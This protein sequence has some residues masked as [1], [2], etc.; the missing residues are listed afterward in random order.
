MVVIQEAQYGA[1]GEC[2]SY[3]QCFCYANF[4]SPPSCSCDDKRKPQCVWDYSY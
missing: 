1:Y 4:S 3:Q 2:D